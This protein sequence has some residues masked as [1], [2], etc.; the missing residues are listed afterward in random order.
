MWVAKNSKTGKNYGEKFDSIYDC[1][2]FIDSK[3]RILEYLYQR[4]VVIERK[5]LED[6]NYEIW[7]KE[8]RKGLGVGEEIML[9]LQF[10]FTEF[11][12]DILNMK[13]LAQDTYTD[14]NIIRCWNTEQKRFATG[15]DF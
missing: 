8:K 9:M 12:K 3:L 7:A 2:N 4:I 14:N 11:S 10:T 6:K 13:D 5:I 15:F 1:Q